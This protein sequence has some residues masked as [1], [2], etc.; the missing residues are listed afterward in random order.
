[1]PARGRR[2]AGATGKTNKGLDVAA[3]ASAEKSAR[4]S[5]VE[6]DRRDNA[7]STTRKPKGP[8]RHA[9]RRVPRDADAASD[10]ASD[11]APTDPS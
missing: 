6:L 7:Q 4:P 1:M 3:T 8:Q 10:L 2:P 11:V 9:S 5:R